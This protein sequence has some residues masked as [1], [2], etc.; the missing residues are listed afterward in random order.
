[1]TPVQKQPRPAIAAP[2]HR[3]PT[4]VMDAAGPRVCDDMSV[5][6]ALSVMT[7]ACAD[8]RV[9]C[10]HDDQG[11]GLVT[12]TE[13]AAVRDS[14]AYPDSVRSRDILSDHAPFTSPAAT[15]AEAGH[16]MCPR[17]LGALPVVDDQGKAL[18]VLA[19]SC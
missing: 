4:E 1:M 13:L 16:A 15:M 19:L 8:R 10:D 7:A 17:R 12:R 5:E 3:K 14:P 9:G 11:T 6:V 18:G 2:A